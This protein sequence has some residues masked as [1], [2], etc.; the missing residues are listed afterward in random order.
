MSARWQQK[1]RQEHAAHGSNT[2]SAMPYCTAQAEAFTLA[3]FCYNHRQQATGHFSL[4]LADQHLVAVANS[5][6]LAAG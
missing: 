6:P 4:H 3:T 5:I 1:Q 2:L